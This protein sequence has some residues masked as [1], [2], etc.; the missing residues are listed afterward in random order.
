MS[1]TPILQLLFDTVFGFFADLLT[2]GI[3]AAL[4]LGA[5]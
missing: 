5:A 4:G 2:D 3:L 1:A